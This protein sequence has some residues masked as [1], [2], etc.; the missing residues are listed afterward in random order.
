M[1]GLRRIGGV[2][3]VWMDGEGLVEFKMDGW[4]RGLVEFKMDGWM[5]KDWWS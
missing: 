1:D 2:K 5:E 4:M 3:D